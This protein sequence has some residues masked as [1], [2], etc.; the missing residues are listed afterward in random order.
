MVYKDKANNLQKTL[1]RKPTDQRSYL[2][3]KYK[4]PSAFESSILLC[5]ILIVKT[6]CSTKGEYQRNCA[7]M[8]EKFLEKKIMKTISINKWTRLTLPNEKK[9]CKIIQKLRARKTYH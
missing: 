3:D 7:V 1:Y 2:H 6:I 5:K 4:Y 9:F 8:K